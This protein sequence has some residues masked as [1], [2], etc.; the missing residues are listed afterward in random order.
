MAQAKKLKG[1]TL[2]KSLVSLTLQQFLFPTHHTL[3]SVLVARSFENLDGCFSDGRSALVVAVC[4][5][6]HLIPFAPRRLSAECHMFCSCLRNAKHVLQQ[7]AKRNAPVELSPDTPRQ[8]R[9][10]AI[11]GCCFIQLGA[12]AGH[13]IS[14]QFAVAMGVLLLVTAFLLVTFR[15]GSPPC[16]TG[17]PCPVA[18]SC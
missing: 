1:V 7:S 15:G 12:F 6:P 10:E 16:T 2:L 4:R 5:V 14:S 8:W 3:C 13:C 9:C 17:P 18:A 11:A